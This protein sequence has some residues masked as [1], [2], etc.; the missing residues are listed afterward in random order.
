[1]P[2]ALRREAG[3]LQCLGIEA[4]PQGVFAY[5]RQRGGDLPHLVGGEVPRA[6]TTQV[7]S[8]LA[9]TENGIRQEWLLR[10]GLFPAQ[11]SMIRY[12]AFAR[13]RHASCRLQNV[14][15]VSGRR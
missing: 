11:P 6:P 10:S 2:S 8:D 13:S 7:L 15:R 3:S 9:P 14:F 5:G 4:P 12:S 1:M